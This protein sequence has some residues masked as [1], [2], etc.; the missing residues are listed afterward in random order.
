MEN[1]IMNTFSLIVHVYCFIV[2]TF[3][4]V[5]VMINKISNNVFDFFFWPY[6]IFKFSKNKIKAIKVE[7]GCGA[8][9]R[10]KDLVKK[11]ANIF[12]KK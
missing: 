12:D 3:L 9:A 1:D 6:G 11:V 4:V 10:H 7:L 8:T 2:I 5:S